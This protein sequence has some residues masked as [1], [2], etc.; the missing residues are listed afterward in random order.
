MK[1]IK[2]TVLLTDGPDVVLLDTDLPCPFVL[3]F[4]PSQFPLQLRF[5]ATAGTGVAYC[6]ETLG[7]KPEVTEV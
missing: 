3:A 1:I 4:S 5:D 7:V 2:A 6:I